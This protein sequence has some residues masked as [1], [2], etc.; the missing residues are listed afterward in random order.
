MRTGAA[1]GADSP[2]YEDPGGW[3]T[4]YVGFIFDTRKTREDDTGVSLENVEKQLRDEVKYYDAYLQGSVIGYTVEKMM[5]CEHGDEHGDIVDSCWGFLYVN[6]S[7]L[8]DVREQALASLPEELRQ[9][10]SVES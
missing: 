7:D 8:A 2:F 4:S 6:E 9:K 10:V 1:I 5:T 3:D